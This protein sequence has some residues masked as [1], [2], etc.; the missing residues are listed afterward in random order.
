MSCVSSWLPPP[1]SSVT[2]NGEDGAKCAS[3]QLCSLDALI[4]PL[5]SLRLLLPSCPVAFTPV[6]LSCCACPWRSNVEDITKL[7]EG[8]F[9]EA[10]GV[11]VGSH[12]DS[13]LED[14]GASRAGG[15]VCFKVVPMGGTTPINGEEQKVR[16]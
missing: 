10:F 8:S 13:L 16:L 1:R 2:S 14:G 5:V 15:S 9:A 4:R 11:V 7:G 6:L 3:R 12:E